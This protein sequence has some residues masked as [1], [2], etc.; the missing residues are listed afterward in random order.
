MN[1]YIKGLFVGAVAVFF[2][3]ADEPRP[4]GLLGIDISAHQGRIEFSK[5]EVQDKHT[6]EWVKPHFIYI[7]ASNGSSKQDN[8]FTYNW[9]ESKTHNFKRGAY[10]FFQ[11]RY[12]GADQ[13]R[14]FISTVGVD[15]GELPPVLD[16]EWM[17][18]YITPNT[19]R[20]ELHKWLN[21]V[22]TEYGTQPIIYTNASYYEDYLK[23]H[24]PGYKFW[25]A[26][27]SATPRLDQ[28]ASFWQYSDRGL[29][30]GI[31][32]NLVDVNYALTEFFKSL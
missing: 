26:H 11:P 18:D 16:I 22:K 19:L 15:H 21:T 8:Y 9:S 27:Y 2:I 17:P 10:H 24:F 13:A 23:G 20:A 31:S 3:A 30:R 25:I 14:L 12:S 29:A 6:G 4:M 28:H 32:E 5:L 7:R 1:R